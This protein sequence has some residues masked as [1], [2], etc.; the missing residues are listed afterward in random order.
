M[1]CNFRIPFE[2]II[3]NLPEKIKGTKISSL[4]LSVN[5]GIVIF[6]CMVSLLL[7]VACHIYLVCDGKIA[8]LNLFYLWENYLYEPS[9]CM[10]ACESPTKFHGPTPNVL[11]KINSSYDWSKEIF[12]GSLY[13]RM[14][15]CCQLQYRLGD[16]RVSR[17]R[18]A[19]SM[20][21]DLHNLGATGVFGVTESMLQ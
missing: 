21:W 4:I 16:P 1:D 2:Y 9:V 6:G 3:E 8:F 19:I 7:V 13:I 12:V 11:V 17:S 15:G 18:I 14:E 20:G 5:A 10:H